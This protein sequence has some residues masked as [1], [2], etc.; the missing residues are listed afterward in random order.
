MKQYNVKYNKGDKVY[1][2]HI[3]AG[4]NTIKIVAGIVNK[5]MIT[6]ELKYQTE[7]VHGYYSNILEDNIFDTKED[8]INRLKDII[9]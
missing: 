6:N 1:G 3:T 9:E 2:I 5:V 8:L 4:T 7:I